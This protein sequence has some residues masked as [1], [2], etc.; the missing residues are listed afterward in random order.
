MRS[1]SCVRGLRSLITGPTR[2]FNRL[3]PHW[4]NKAPLHPNLSRPSL[5]PRVRT[6]RPSLPPRVRSVGCF[7]L[8]LFRSFSH[9]SQ[10]QGSG[11]C[12]PTSGLKRIAGRTAEQSH[13]VVA[14]Y[15]I[16]PQH[17]HGFIGQC[18]EWWSNVWHQS[19][20]SKDARICNDGSIRYASN[21]CYHERSAG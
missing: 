18:A 16:K 19:S 9:A 5:P 13:H 6:V 21:K 12:C 7:P 1:R 2:T 15:G 4:A 14:D 17:C 3:H 8:A 20:R 11:C 10:R